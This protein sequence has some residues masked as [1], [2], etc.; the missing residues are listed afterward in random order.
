MTFRRQLS[1]SHP[2][3]VKIFDYITIVGADY[4][5]LSGSG[6]AIYGLFED[7][8]MADRAAHKLRGYGLTAWSGK[9]L[10]GN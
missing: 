6:S 9:M 7:G 5:S 1:K 8:E 2:E 4:V 3:L 10:S